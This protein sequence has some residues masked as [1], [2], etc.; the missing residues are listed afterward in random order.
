VQEV[1]SWCRCGEAGQAD[2]GAAQGEQ[3]ETEPRLSQGR[4]RTVA[5]ADALEQ[6]QLLALEDGRQRQRRRE[7]GGV[8]CS[9]R[10]C[11]CTEVRG[12]TE[13]LGWGWPVG[14]SQEMSKL[15]A[16]Y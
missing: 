6:Q 14:A 2:P 4:A 3:R 16:G 5:V 13:E 10:R 11:E 9:S 8:R 1:L 15:G 7:S 12:R